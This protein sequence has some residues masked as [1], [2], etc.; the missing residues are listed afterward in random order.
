MFLSAASSLTSPFTGKERDAET[1]LDYFGARY[2]SGAQGRFLSS[3]PVTITPERLR[4]PQQLNAYAYVRNNPLRFI[5]PT[6]KILQLSGDTSA[7]MDLLCSI[8][9]PYCPYLDLGA[10]NIVVFHLEEE[11]AMKDEGALLIYQL[12]HSDF[13]YDL[14]VGTRVPTAGEPFDFDNMSGFYR[15]LPPFWDQ[16]E[17]ARKRQNRWLYPG[18]VAFPDD[19]P[20]IG[21]DAEIAFTSRPFTAISYTDRRPALLWTRV[22]H[23]LA[24]AFEKIDGPIGKYD[25]GHANA[26]DRERKLRGQ[27]LVNEHPYLKD[28][29]MG[30]GE[31]ENIIITR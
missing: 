3:D 9:G 15:N 2:F 6:G 8:A 10:N 21:I 12:V 4:D 31:P 20:A 24:E 30:A 11:K 27:R 25:V 13:L 14:F 16:Q 17:A 1:G 23:E 29:N 19:F 5:D 18:I 26:A 7:G 28:Y 22:F